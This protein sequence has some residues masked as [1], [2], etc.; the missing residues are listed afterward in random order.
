MKARPTSW[1][2]TAATLVLGLTAVIQRA[3]FAAL[4]ALVLLTSGVHA[5]APGRPDIQTLHLDRSIQL[6][7]SAASLRD[8][9][10][11]PR[12]RQRRSAPENRLPLRSTSG[13]C[14]GYSLR[15]LTSSR[16]E[17]DGFC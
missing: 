6:R 7:F 9:N 2:V 16:S 15:A 3:I 11:S 5:D 13:L 8:Q 12:H 1:I 4:V 14:R 17:F 10:R